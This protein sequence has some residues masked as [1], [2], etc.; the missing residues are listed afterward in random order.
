MVALYF[1]DTIW[2][3]GTKLECPKCTTKKNTIATAVTVTVAAEITITVSSSSSFRVVNKKL[4]ATKR[5]TILDSFTNIHHHQTYQYGEIGVSSHLHHLVNPQPPPPPPPLP[6]PPLIELYGLLEKQ[7]SLLEEMSKKMG[8]NQQQHL[9][10]KQ[11]PSPISSRLALR[12]AAAGE[13]VEVQGGHI[14]RSTGRKDRHSKVCTAK[15]PRDRRVRLSAH[16]AIQFYDVQDRLGYDRPSKAVDW[17]LKKAKPAID[18]LAELPAWKPNATTTIKN[19]KE[20]QEGEKDK[21]NGIEDDGDDEGMYI[22]RQDQNQQQ[23]HHQ[24]CNNGDNN[25]GLLPPSLDSDDTIKS[26][27]PAGGTTTHS[28]VASAASSSPVQPILFANYPSEFMSRSCSHSQDLRLSLQQSLQDPIMMHQH[29]HHQAAQQHPYFTGAAI[30]QHHHLV[31]FDHGHDHDHDHSSAG[32]VE[33]QP[34]D[35]ARCQRLVT[36]WNADDDTGGNV[37]SGFIFNPPPST[38]PLLQ[39]FFGQL[40]SQREPL[41]SSNNNHNNTS[42]PLF[43]AWISDVSMSNATTD[44]QNHQMSSMHPHSMAAIGFAS[45]GFSGFHIPARIQGDEEHDGNPNRLSASRH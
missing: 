37:G 14:V 15:G 13:I 21:I 43:R 24:I 18:E 7:G 11:K 17:L 5:K 20:E 28:E 12:N 38:S 10:Q 30:S 16:T 23:Q 41:Q 2:G 4:G 29:H 3:H 32:W 36:G 39:P 9:Q 19:M 33:N 40:F 1:F 25:T 26:F 27:F 31:G 42:N 22:G 35:M 34:A 44:H 8:D 6:Q 45:S